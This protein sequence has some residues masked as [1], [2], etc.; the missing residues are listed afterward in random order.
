MFSDLTLRGNWFSLLK[1]Y[2]EAGEG[3][4]GKPV[5]FRT[6]KLIAV[7]LLPLLGLAIGF[8]WAATALQ[9]DI[10]SRILPRQAIDLA[11]ANEGEAAATTNNPGKSH[12]DG[13]ASVLAAGT[14][15]FGAASAGQAISNSAHEHKG[16]APVMVHQGQDPR[17]SAV[18]S[19]TLAYAL[20]ESTPNSAATSGTSTRNPTKDSVDRLTQGDWL[21]A[22]LCFILPLLVPLALLIYNLASGMRSRAKLYSAIL[23]I[24]VIGFALLRSVSW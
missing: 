24:Q 19:R 4:F 20:S 22:V 5:E 14:L 3:V 8:R 9:R 6:G 7:C 11:R 2:V 23:G 21:M 17:S 18:G 15:G 12:D 13:D 16:P 10:D 1:G